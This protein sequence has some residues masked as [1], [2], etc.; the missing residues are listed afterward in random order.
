MATRSSV[1]LGT[2]FRSDIPGTITGARFYKGALNTGTHVATLWTNT[3]TQLATATFTGETASGWQQVSFATPVPIAAN[4]TYVISYLA[5]KGHYSGQDNYFTAAGIDNL[6]LHALKDAT[7]GP[8][9]VYAYSTT[10][11]FPTQTFLSE[12]YFVDVVFNTN[13]P[14]TVPP[15]ISALSASAIGTSTATI[16]WTTNEPADSA[17]H[18]GTDS[19]SLTQTASNPALVTSHNVGL[20][21][22]TPNTTYFYRVTSADAAGNLATLPATGQPASLRTLVAVPSVVNLTQ[23]AATTAITSAGLMVGTVTTSSSATVAGGVGHQSE[24]GGGTSVARAVR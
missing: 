4:T 17:V 8:N 12:G 6:P 19:A 5:P 1:V 15:T 11:I 23:A 13:G 14:D 21:G 3:G 10:N 20:T 16:T 22:L 2:R 24:P 7:D 18:F 9:G